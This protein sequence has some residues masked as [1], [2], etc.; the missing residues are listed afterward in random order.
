MKTSIRKIRLGPSEPILIILLLS[1]L[2]FFSNTLIGCEKKKGSHVSATEQNESQITD[3]STVQMNLRKYLAR[4]QFG[5]DINLDYY[6]FI[7]ASDSIPSNFKIN[8]DFNLDVSVKHSPKG[9]EIDIPIIV[10]SMKDTT[11]ALSIIRGGFC[12]GF[13][14]WV[15]GTTLFAEKG[16]CD[17]ETL[18]KDP[19]SVWLGQGDKLSLDFREITDRYW[20]NYN[21]SGEAEYKAKMHGAIENLGIA[22]VNNIPPLF[23][24]SEIAV[25]TIHLGK[26]KFR[27]EK[28]DAY[29][30]VITP[31]EAELSQIGT[32]MGTKEGLSKINWVKWNKVSNDVFKKMVVIT[33][34]ITK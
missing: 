8:S 26:A 13:G 32:I 34:N 3:L 2:M 12:C 15:K 19:V 11:G 7:L 23:D 27:E 28:L 31:P 21:E 16:A 17:T 20:G 18:F 4:M 10:E 6:Q 5:I 14:H 25:I 29:G 22:C 9:F 1:M 30:N 33:S 24:P